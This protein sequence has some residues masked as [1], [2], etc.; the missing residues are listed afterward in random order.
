ML[1]YAEINLAEDVLRIMM[2]TC[3]FDSGAQHN[4]IFFSFYICTE[5]FVLDYGK[6]K[7]FYIT[8]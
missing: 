3:H 7:K 2:V 4:I 6:R 1:P 8:C 5:Y